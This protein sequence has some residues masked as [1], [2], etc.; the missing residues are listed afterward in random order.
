[1]VFLG[2]GVGNLA[3]IYAYYAISQ[4]DSSCLIN[5]KSSTLYWISG[6]TKDCRICLACLDFEKF[7][8][9]LLL[10]QL[11]IDYLP[12]LKGSS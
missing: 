3:L 6:A 5:E 4:K 9:L 10:A 7:N 8:I 12:S 11:I 2:G 1:L